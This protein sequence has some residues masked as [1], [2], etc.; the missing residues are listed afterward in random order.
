MSMSWPLPSFPLNSNGISWLEEFLGPVSKVPDIG[1]D[2][3]MNSQAII[4]DGKA[5]L[6]FGPLSAA[7]AG[8][9]AFNDFLG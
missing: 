8:G 6:T 3:R 4:F 1:E 5:Y 7:S 2:L 9:P